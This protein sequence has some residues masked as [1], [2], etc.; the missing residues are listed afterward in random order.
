MKETRMALES[1][2]DLMLEEL[3]DLYD[4]EH[5]I[6]EALPKMAKAA[7]SPELK[8]GFEEHL[9]QS[10][11]QIQRL[12]QV[13]ENLGERAKRKTCKA[14]KGLI[15]EG[16]DMIKEDAESATKD[17][18]LIG[19]AQRVEHYE[20]AGYGTARRFA[21]VMG[22]NEVYDLLTQTLDEESMTDERLTML[23]DTI[24]VEAN[25]GLSGSMSNQN[26]TRSE[27]TRNRKSSSRSTSMSN[28][29]DSKSSG[30]K[31][32]NGRSSSKEKS[33]S[34]SKEKAR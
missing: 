15:K 29:S 34:S 18:G 2:H 7:T 28:K 16:E 19:A 4:A 25:G 5:Q 10:Q 32:S 12:E 6:V 22:H 33:A 26:Q 31:S 27:L 8:R 13:F 3:Q 9:R 1:L 21:K 14:M 17:A 20:I 11:V 30:S 24:N 23:S